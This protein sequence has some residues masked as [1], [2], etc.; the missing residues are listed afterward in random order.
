MLLKNGQPISGTDKL[1]LPNW[2]YHQ[3]AYSF[4]EFVGQ[5]TNEG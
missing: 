2:C 3:Q 4:A 5:K 1:S